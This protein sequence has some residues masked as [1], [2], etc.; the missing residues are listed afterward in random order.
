MTAVL[1]EKKATKKGFSWSHEASFEA[2]KLLYSLYNPG[3][4]V[5]ARGWEPIYQRYLEQKSAFHAILGKTGRRVIAGESLTVSEQEIARILRNALGEL[6]PFPGLYHPEGAAGVTWPMYNK[7]LWTELVKDLLRDGLLSA[8]NSIILDPRL[9]VILKERLKPGMK[10][11]K[12][13]ATLVQL[14]AGYREADAVSMVSKQLE[15]I[16]SKTKPQ[17]MVVSANILDFAMASWHCPWNSCH[18]PDGEMRTGPIQYMQESMTLLVYGYSALATPP[19][20]I[21]GDLKL[22]L[23]TWRAMIHILPGKRGKANVWKDPHFHVDG[24]H[25]VDVDAPPTVNVPASYGG[26]PPNEK[27]RTIVEGLLDEL[28]WDRSKMKWSVRPVN[29]KGPN[30]IAY[31]D[32]PRDSYTSDTSKPGVYDCDP[33]I[34]PRCGSVGKIKKQENITRAELQCVECELLTNDKIV[35][36]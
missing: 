18:R 34:C 30:Q 33:V 29:A 22:P 17:K 26:G 32:T 35:T 11:S 23:K 25:V 16:E 27:L 15:V 36:R 6:T 7:G 19:K 8:E 28:G 24:S 10:V 5:D 4:P 9:P 31:L 12:A 20:A 21:V 1:K 13:M 14:C 2:T 3:L